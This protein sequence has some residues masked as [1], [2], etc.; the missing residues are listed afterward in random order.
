MVH[1]QSDYIVEND[2]SN[3][4]IEVSNW[5]SFTGSFLQASDLKS[6]REES[7]LVGSKGM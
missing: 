5:G 2:K 7:I 4:K 1:S 3:Q 6:E